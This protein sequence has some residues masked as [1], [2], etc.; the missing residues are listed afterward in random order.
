MIGRIRTVKPELFLD[1]ELWELAEETGLPIVQAFVGMFCYA[2]REGRFEWRPRTLKSVILPYWSGDFSRV[3]DALESRRFLVRY[4]C[5]EREYGYVR[6][7]AR[8][9]VINNRERPSEIP[10][11]GEGVPSEGDSRLGFIY[12]ATCPGA[13]AFKVGFSKYDPRKRVADLSAGS[14]E[15][16]ELVD[17]VEGERA[18]E[19]AIHRA[20]K[21][22]HKHR[23]WFVCTTES[24]EALHAWFTR[25]PR[26][27]DAGKAEGNGMELEWKGGEGDRASATPPVPG[28]VIVAEPED[29]IRVI[30]GKGRFAPENLEPT[31]AQRVRC[32]ELRFEA[33]ELMRDFK[34]QEFNREYSD[35]EKRFSRWIEDQ[36]LR[37]E[38][39]QAKPKSGPRESPSELDTTGAA[40]AFR[41]DSEHREFATK[42]GR[43]SDLDAFAREYAQGETCKRL[44]T[45]GQS[46]DFMNRLKC[47]AHTGQW[48]P[49]GP[50]P[51]PPVKAREVRA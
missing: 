35:W 51:K 11:P 16:L 17:V 28:L 43:R 36:K 14:P 6:T 4:R 18:L 26:D 21:P 38:T 44:D 41:L 12:V 46:R 13:S 22:H 39:E 33:D 32:R 8:H 37:R 7:F 24:C 47:L 27:V 45:L 23:E 31:M 42:L 34:L 48:H 10:P 29:V 9:Q 15:P 30:P 5:G 3:L 25:D 49:D 2:D 50:L 40:L 1:E 19:T 20:L